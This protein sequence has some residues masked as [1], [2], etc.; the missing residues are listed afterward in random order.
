MVESLI[1]LKDLAKKFG[2][3]IATSKISMSVRRGEIFGFLGANGAGKTT[4]IRMLCGLT[5]PTSGTG[6]IGGLDIWK[7]RFRIR[8]RFGY[9]PQ[10][11]SLYADL[12]VMENLRFFGEAYGVPS[13]KINDRINKVV[14]D[15]DLELRERERAGRL[16]G[17]YKQLLAIACAL[18]HEPTLLFL[19]EP[20]AGLDPTHSQAIWDLI[21]ELSQSGTTIF[22]TTHYMDEAE[23]CTDVG[24]VDGGRLIAKGTPRDL[25]E[26]LKGH[27]LEVQ[28]E[29]AMAAMFELR[30]LPGVYGADLRSG[31]LRL[32]V[33]DPDALLHS[34]QIHWPFPN[35]RF[36][37]FNWVEPDMESVFQAFSRGYYKPN[38]DQPAP[39]K[40]VYKI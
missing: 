11:F 38:G 37:G 27:L 13:V 15:M 4:T 30:K 9:V 39:A 7:D 33:E 31:N 19:D 12:T 1:V 18:I 21:Y 2:K 29:P 8:S 14:C 40:L 32:Q 17:G 3:K 28:V 34:W 25:K 36:L 35:L 5:K 22:V 26:R 6:S 10:K 16:S 24:F 20:T 23:R